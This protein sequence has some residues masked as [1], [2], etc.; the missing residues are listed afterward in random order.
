MSEVTERDLRELE[1]LLD[2]LRGWLES[3][4]ELA[5]KLQLEKKF[6]G[7]LGEAVAI[8]RLNEVIG[9]RVLGLDW[10]GGQKSGYDVEVTLKSG[11]KVR[12]QVKSTTTNNF[13]IF[14]LGVS[15]GCERAIREAH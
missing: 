9:S 4:K 5:A 10:P 2:L 11:R 6:I 15:G 7:P 1:G 13:Q 8:I 12:L 3:K 14:S